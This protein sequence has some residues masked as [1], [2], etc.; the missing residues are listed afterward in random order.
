MPD[1]Y[2]TADPHSEHRPAE[3]AFAYRGHPLAFTTDSGVFSR[4]ALD[5]GTEEL[6]AALPPLSGDVLDLGCGYGAI[7]VA[8][9][10]ANPGARVVMA[11]INTRAVALAAQNAA[12]NSVAAE[13]LVSDGF[14]ALLPR[15]FAA[16]MQN[17]P[18]RAGKAAIYRMFADASRSLIPGGALYLV[19]RKQQGAPSAIAYLRTLFSNVSILAKKAGYWMLQCQNPIQEVHAMPTLD[20][21]I[22]SYR[23]ELLATLT[24]WIAVPSVKA[25]PAPGAPFGPE[26][27]R[28]LDTA[29]ADCAAMGFDTRDFAGYACD[30]RMGAIGVEPLAVLGHLDVV[31]AGDGWTT[32]PFAATVDGGRVY[33]RGTSDDKGPALAA[34]FAMRA[35][36]EAGVPLKREI[37][38]ILGCDEESGWQDIDYYVAHCDMPKTGFSPD[39][40]FPL[41]NTEKG[42][43]HLNL[44]GAYDGALVRRIA[45]GERC[46]V[47]PG[48]ASALVAGDKTAEIA[49]F[50]KES[51][52]DVRATL[53]NG[54]TLVETFGVP[55]HAAYPTIARNAIGMLLLSLRALGVTGPLK[56]LADRVG[57][58]YDGLSLGARC[59]DETSGPLTCNLG[60]L[61]YDENG[62]FATLDIRYPLLAN[63][64]ALRET[65]T[66]ALQPDVTVALDS[67]KVPHH[68][69][70]SSE[71][72]QALLGAYHDKSGLPPM[73]VATGGGTYARCLEE[74]VAFGCSF[75]DDED[76]AHQAG[77]Y[78]DIDKLLLSAKIFAEALV[79]L[80]GE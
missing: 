61:R 70:P 3:V 35:L 1:Q 25:S 27:R 33:G 38:L 72:V 52:L 16:I 24:R 71:L 17:P 65:I 2:Y 43:L 4:L 5:R 6:L 51:G 18:I 19:I 7:G 20:S 50:A 15:T 41:I 54:D 36:K 58:E 8:L 21:L 64:D 56:T 13:T 48:H 62:L 12:R 67:V 73:C 9:A 80:A 68:V 55:G 78:I 30:A 49:A 31:P 45:V 34:L 77:E 59:S 76:L 57:M 22:D 23:D 26:V 79:R 66:A 40:S 39:A 42:G 74:G 44:S 63:P 28:A 75:P 11:D 29:L 10:A 37:R 60:I 53:T 69:A 47:I 32:E 46:N 14:S